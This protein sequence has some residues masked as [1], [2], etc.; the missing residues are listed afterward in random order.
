MAF[1]KLVDLDVPNQDFNHQK[2]SVFENEMYLEKIPEKNQF[3][4]KFVKSASNINIDLKD[5]KCQCMMERKHPN[6]TFGMPPLPENQVW[7][8]ILNLLMKE[9]NRSNVKFAALEL[10]VN[11]TWKH[12]GIEKVHDEKKPF[13]CEIC[14]TSYQAKQGLKTLIFSTWE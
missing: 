9:S 1:E 10:P 13:K 11:L 6:V 2:N 12:I 7:S 4:V 8:N 5:T 14:Q 3:N